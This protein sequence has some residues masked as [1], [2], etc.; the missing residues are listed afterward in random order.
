MKLIKKLYHD[1]ERA[2]ENKE[3]Y[4]R[5]QIFFKGKYAKSNAVVDHMTFDYLPKIVKK[6]LKLG[7]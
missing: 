4:D 6:L 5:Y 3:F 7:S 1:F 2:S